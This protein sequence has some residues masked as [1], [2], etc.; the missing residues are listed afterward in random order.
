[1]PSPPTADAVRGWA[2]HYHL[3]QIQNYRNLRQ[4]ENEWKKTIMMQQRELAMISG[5]IQN[6]RQRG[7]DTKL[8]VDHLH[9]LSQ[10]QHWNRRFVIRRPSEFQ[11]FEAPLT[12]TGSKMSVFVDQFANTLGAKRL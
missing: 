5:Q 4:A 1:M 8:L 11:R 3:L 9:K 2:R 7:E 6:L 10:E 12:P